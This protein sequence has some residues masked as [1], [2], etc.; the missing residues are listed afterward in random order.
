MNSWTWESRLNVMS[1]REK[2]SKL[3]SST[4]KALAGETW[5]IRDPVRGS[6]WLDKGGNVVM[7]L[8][9]WVRPD[10]AGPHGPNKDLSLYPEATGSPQ[11]V[12]SKTC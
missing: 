5:Y 1:G 10:R 3:R 4:R 6:V 11:N 7:K 2:H 9:R 12:F 8:K